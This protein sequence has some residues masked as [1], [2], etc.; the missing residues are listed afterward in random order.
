M[1]KQS[2]IGVFRTSLCAAAIAPIGIL[3]AAG[4]THIAPVQHTADAPAPAATV[5]A[6]P[7]AFTIAAPP[8]ARTPAPTPAPAPAPAPVI[9][10]ASVTTGAVPAS[11][12][13]AYEKAAKIMAR[14]TPRCGIDWKL[15]AGIGRVESHHADQGNVDHNGELKSPIFGPTLNGTL[16]GNQVIADTDGGRLDG[17]TSYDRAIGPM[18]FL[19]QTWSHYAADGNGDGKIDPQNIYDA[20]LTTARYLCDGN[21]D[22]RADA[23]RVTAI[24]R[25]NNSMT[26]VDDVL[27][28]ARSY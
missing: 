10:P 16:A 5:V 7:A 25:Y 8:A 20:A 15:I 26:Y 12:Y 1:R 21:L 9:R 14:T 11:N 4:A 3:A 27:G 19:P 22:L 24:L 17:D 6:A 18:Q 13:D 28:Y 23:S 2:K